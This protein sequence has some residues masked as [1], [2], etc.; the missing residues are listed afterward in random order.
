M[1][2]PTFP[3]HALATCDG[4]SPVHKANEVCT[5]DDL[6]VLVLVPDWLCDGDHDSVFRKYGL[7]FREGYLVTPSGQVIRAERTKF[8]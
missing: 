7:T 4:E 6:T 1:T 8:T 2:D 5:G 3:L